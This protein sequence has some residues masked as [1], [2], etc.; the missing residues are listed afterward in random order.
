MNKT[1]VIL[2]PGYLPW[3]G[4]FNLMLRSDVFVF[5]DDVQY[6]KH[7][8]RNRNRV[9][10]PVGPHWLTVP[11]LHHGQGKPTNLDIA[12]TQ[13]QRWAKKHLGTLEQFYRKAPF[14]AP[15]LSELRAI[16]EQPWE[17][18]VDLNLAVTDWFNEKF[19]IKRETHRSSALKIEGGQTERLVKICQYFGATDYL[20]GE[21]AKSYLEVS[22][23]DAAGIKVNW[24][25]FSPP[26]YP[27]QFGEFVPGLSALDLL[28]NVGPDSHKLLA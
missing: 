11:V 19:E 9:K 28:L 13:H 15:Y 5:Y 10:A 3:P 17:K 24:H 1:V 8:W 25:D 16:L 21:S 22:Q 14:S 27:Q 6:D 2:Q 23:F 12:I 20:S 26:T 7:G 18:L 4:F